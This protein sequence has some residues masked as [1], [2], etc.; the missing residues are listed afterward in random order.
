MKLLSEYIYI[1]IYINALFALI[2]L[3]SHRLHLSSFLSTSPRQ[4]KLALLLIQIK[5]RAV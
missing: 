1:Y 2:L 5:G 4:T 3:A